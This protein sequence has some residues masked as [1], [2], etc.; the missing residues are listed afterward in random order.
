MRRIGQAIFLWGIVCL[1]GYGVYQWY[2]LEPSFPQ[3]LILWIPL[4]VLG[5]VGMLRVPGWK[6][7][8]VVRVWFVVSVGGML[9]HFAFANQWLPALIPNPWAYWALLMAIG[10]AATGK[11]L[12]STYWYAVSALNLLFF[13]GSNFLLLGLLG[14]YQSVLLGIVSGIPLLYEGLRE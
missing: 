12:R 7:N 8:K 9:Y 10:F 11:L 2:L 5:I 14:D 13:L 4:T 1:F 6:H 3:P